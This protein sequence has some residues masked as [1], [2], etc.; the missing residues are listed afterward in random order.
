MPEITSSSI[1]EAWQEAIT[2]THGAIRREVFNLEVTIT[3]LEQDVEENPE[4]RAR[5]DS[6]LINAD[7]AKVGTVANTIFPVRLWNPAQPRGDLFARYNALWPKIRRH[8]NN[9]RG[10]Y[11][12]R[13]ISYPQPGP[14]SFNQLDQ[15]ISTYLSG[16]HRRSALQAS[17]IV[18]SFDLTNSR[19]QGFPC[20]QQLAF[21]PRP[22]GRLRV[23]GF[24]P[25]QYIYQRGYG[26]YLGLINLGRF[27]AAEM[28]LSLEAITC[29]SSV[30]KLDRPSS[31]AAFILP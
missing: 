26:N 1:S 17:V 3:N 15:I 23:L 27:M 5:L 6:A 4:L 11:F 16:N 12:Q 13:L 8:H 29:I 30:A 31:A 21:L 9:R 10:T 28:N 14:E 2:L 20:M 25:I 24:Y 18:P 22:A 7:L 19:Q